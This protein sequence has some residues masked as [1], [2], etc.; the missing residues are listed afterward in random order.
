MK[1]RTG[2]VSNSS[3]S[4]F[5]LALSPKISEI[6]P[7]CGRKSMLLES[8]SATTNYETAISDKDF[9]QIVEYIED[10]SSEKHRQK[11][12]DET[13][14][15]F[16]E[17]WKILLVELSYHDQH[18]NNLLDEELGKGNIKILFGD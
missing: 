4:S 7:H 3:S 15:L 10:N 13:A 9:N 18:N 5:V 16:G 11:V 17:G 6:C 1:I 12:L 8:L 2:F 14:F